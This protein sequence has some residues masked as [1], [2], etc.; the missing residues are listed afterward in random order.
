MYSS[1]TVTSTEDLFIECFLLLTPCPVPS[2]SAS[3]YLCSKAQ[4]FTS[5]FPGW[6]FSEK[7]G[8]FWSLMQK[9]LNAPLTDK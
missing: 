1:F 8:G 6:F 9:A 5:R 2:Y 4:S 7:F 3:I